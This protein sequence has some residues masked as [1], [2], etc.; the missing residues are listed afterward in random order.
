MALASVS[1]WIK[2]SLFPNKKAPVAPGL[3]E[4]MTTRLTNCKRDQCL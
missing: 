2:V 4:T 1:P 3:L